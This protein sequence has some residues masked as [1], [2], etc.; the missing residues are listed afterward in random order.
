MCSCRASGQGDTT[1]TSRGGTGGSRYGRCAGPRR[2]RGQGHHHSP[3]VLRSDQ[4]DMGGS[5][6]TAG[7][8]NGNWGEL[9]RAGPVLTPAPPWG[10][11]TPPVPPSDSSKSPTEASLRERPADS[12]T[13][14]L[15]RH[16]P[17]RTRY[18]GSHNAVMKGRPP[19]AEGPKGTSGPPRWDPVALEGGGSG[20]RDGAKSRAGGC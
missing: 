13:F 16:H 17:A 20:S 7:Q 2:W 6:A 15:P 5:C 4:G 11:P 1:C 9:R 12:S 10:P 19:T 8:R 18:P 14:A 3:H